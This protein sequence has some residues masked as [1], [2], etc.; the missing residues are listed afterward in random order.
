MKKIFYYIYAVVLT[1]GLASCAKENITVPEDTP[2]MTITATL[3]DE[4]STKTSLFGD[5]QTGYKVLW[6]EG[7]QI[8]IYN[9]NDSQYHTYTLSAGEGTTVGIFTGDQLQDGT[10]IATFGTDFTY[11]Q[12]SGTLAA[13]QHF[14][15]ISDASFIPMAAKVNIWNGEPSFAS[16]KNVTGFLRLSL[17]GIGTLKSIKVI[18]DQY[19]SGMMTLENDGAAKVTPSSLISRKNV[20]L[21]CG[22]DG[23]DLGSDA[24]TF[25]ISLP[26]GEYTGLKIEF[27]DSYGFVRTKTLKADKTLNIARSKINPISL[28]VNFPSGKSK[29]TING[30]EVYVR[31]FQLW[32]NGPK[33]AEYNI[34]VTNGKPESYGEKYSWGGFTNMNHD[35]YYKGNGEIPLNH[36]T[37]THIWGSNWRTPS[38][39]DIDAFVSH[40]NN[41][42]ITINSVP[43]KQFTGKDNYSVYSVFFPYCSNDSIKECYWT[44]STQTGSYKWSF[45]LRISLGNYSHWTS[46]A[47]FPV[48]AICIE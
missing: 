18:T 16:F 44:R 21:A 1:L 31:W 26:K 4:E 48:R 39:G 9:P 24:K 14:T 40:T 5:E 25:Y 36:D 8:K 3:G 15:S 47:C 45:S 42:E 33:W 22:N 7:D 13:E 32:E 35:D 12:E 17:D 11:K 27:T 30:Q 46:Y 38:S 10:Y 28:T 34:G 20:T 6:A 29:A 37:A 19:I 23:I 41:S 43:G 2:Q